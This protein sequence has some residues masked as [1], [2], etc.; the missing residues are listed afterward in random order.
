[1]KRSFAV[2][3]CLLA[4]AAF[5]AGPAFA[6]SWIKLG[7]RTLLLNSGE[8]EVKVKSEAAVSELVIQVK[9][10]QVNLKEVK[11]S[12]ADGTE[13]TIEVNQRLRPGIDSEPIGLGASGALKSVTLVVDGSQF[14][15]AD[16]VPTTVFGK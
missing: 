10:L 15:A 4:L 14:L 6:D 1:M 3:L 16:R 2:A 8:G 9:S 5:A 7:S 12:F 11:V 13:K